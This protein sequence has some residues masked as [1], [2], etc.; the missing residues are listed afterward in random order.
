M[1]TA[2]TSFPFKCSFP[3]CSKLFSFFGI[4]ENRL[5]MYARTMSY[6]LIMIEQ[7]LCSYLLDIFNGICD[8]TRIRKNRRL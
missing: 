5:A 1:D 7:I 2:S 6:Q 8:S 4:I 3:N